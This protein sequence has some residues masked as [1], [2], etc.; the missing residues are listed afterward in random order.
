AKLLHE[1]GAFV[2]V[3]LLHDSLVPLFKQ[4]KYLVKVVPP[5]ENPPPF[6]F[7]IPMMNLPSVFSTT[8]TSI[9]AQTPYLEIEQKRIDSWKNK[10]KFD[11][12]HANTID[13]KPNF[14][15]GI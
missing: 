10:L 4:Q 8:L 1:R 9:P 2:V 6:H 7:Q 15:I 11:L 3:H 5:H 12:S 14:K 13:S